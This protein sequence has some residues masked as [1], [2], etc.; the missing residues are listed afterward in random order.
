MLFPRMHLRVHL[1]TLPSLGIMLYIEGTVPFLL[2]IIAALLHEL[3]HVLAVKSIGAQ[4][5]RVDIMPLGARIVTVCTLSHKADII[6]YLFGPLFNLLAAC[7]FLPTGFALKNAFVLYFGVVNLFLALVNLLPLAGNDGY[8]ALVSF[9]LLH[10]G[11]DY[12]SKKE[13]LIKNVAN[14]V[15]LLLSAMAVLLSGFNSGILCLTAAATVYK[16]D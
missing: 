8:Q 4:I 10:K 6:M 16:K 2:F 11:E 3:G 15:F 14:S 12:T 7:L 13:K 5:K 9:H 1:L